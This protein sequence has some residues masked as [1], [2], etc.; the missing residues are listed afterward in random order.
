[1]YPS[2]MN[3]SDLDPSVAMVRTPFFTY[4]GIAELVGCPGLSRRG[5]GNLK[6]E[7]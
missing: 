2:R 1:M 4:S 3:I 7:Y 6:D 5:L